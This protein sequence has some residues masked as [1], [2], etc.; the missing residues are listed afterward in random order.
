MYSVAPLEYEL[1]R[2][3]VL[4][5][6]RNKLKAGPVWLICQDSSARLIWLERLFKRLQ[7]FVIE[8][9]L[10]LALNYLKLSVFQGLTNDHFLAN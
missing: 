8:R 5:V 1:P 4:A 7:T 10:S 2:I 3:P 6:K 9:S